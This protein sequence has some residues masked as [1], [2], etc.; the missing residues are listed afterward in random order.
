MNGV[1]EGIGRKEKQMKGKKI[2]QFRGK[3]GGSL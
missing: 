3:K 1:R 2:S